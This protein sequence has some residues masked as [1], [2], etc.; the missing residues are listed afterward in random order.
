MISILS[1]IAD[2][3]GQRQNKRILRLSFPQDDGPKAVLLPHKFQANEALSRDF[4]FK[5]EL[6]AE[7]ARIPL[8]DMLGKLITISLV[9]GD[10]TLRYFTGYV[11][12]FR[13]TKTDGGFAFYEMVLKPWLAYLAQ[14]K[15]NIL[16]H[17]QTLRDVTTSIFQEYCGYP[18]WDCRL[19]SEDPEIT[20]SCQFDESD[21]NYLHRRWEASGWHYWY[22]H[23]ER[24]H[25]LI[26]SD[27]S[28][29]AAVIDGDIGIEFQRHAGALEEEGLGD[30]S[31][32]RRFA[33]TSVAL[34]GF[35]FKNARPQ[36]CGV[37]SVNEQGAVPLVETYEYTG[38]Y[39]FADVARGSRQ[40]TLRMEEIEAASKHF[41]GG[42]NC[43]RVQPGRSFRLDKHFEDDDDA[44]QCEFLI[45]SV[46]HEASNN[47]L[48]NIDE[49]A[50]YDNQMVCIRKKIPWRPGR[51]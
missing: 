30:W 44:T 24:G 21:H 15:N 22:E 1:N 29:S 51:A 11:F 41:D 34:S 26:L 7:D 5:V 23:D 9:R 13:L 2:L 45:L 35:D 14:R 36:H 32:V 4:E 47:Y 33:A 18:N 39:G 49:P 16:F 20:M 38:A 42:G 3:M 10:G 43:R 48:Q 19:E 50:H 40:A 28:T 12:E 46:R 31:P 17:H 37:D 8:K 25:T 27:N 6:L